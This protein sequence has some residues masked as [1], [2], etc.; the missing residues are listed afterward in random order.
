MKQGIEFSVGAVS[1][2]A[3]PE[4]GLHRLTRHVMEQAK[5]KHDV[6]VRTDAMS[7][8]TEQG[9]GGLVT[10]LRVKDEGAFAVNEHA[11]RQVRA[12]LGIDYKYYDRIRDQFAAIGYDEQG[13]PITKSL[14][15]VNVNH[16]MHGMGET[17]L[18]R[19][20]D[21][22]CRAFLSD[23][24]RPM[25]NEDLLEHILPVLLEMGGN[26]DVVSCQVTDAK[27]YLKLVSRDRWAEVKEGSVVQVGVCIENSEIGSGAISAIP[28]SVV[29]ACNNGMKH[30]QFGTRRNHVGSRIDIG[31]AASAIF[32]DETY[33]AD[34]RAYWLKVRDIVK[35]ALSDDILN[36]I[37]DQMREAEGIKIVSPVEAVKVLANKY[38]LNEGE[39]NTVLENLLSGAHG[40]GKDNLYGLANAVTYTAGTVDDYDR[41]TD[42]EDLGGKLLDLPN[43]N[44]TELN[45]L[46]NAGLR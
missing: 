28:F 32:S 41:A 14:L 7:Y 2:I 6:L 9:D 29:K 10:K 18:V 39:T 44:K 22:T 26:L 19:T 23:K 20:L 30:T 27:L 36:K 12:Y 16:W 25:D 34:D 43:G 35:A 42:L 21:G 46:V 5:L 37:A 3:N 24:Y 8:V 13:N 4:S 33:R 31:D 45:D 11:H 38:R 15:D 40:A 17:R 1:D